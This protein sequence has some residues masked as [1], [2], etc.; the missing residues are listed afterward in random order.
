MA[1]TNQRYETLRD[2][3]KS[4][5][6]PLAFVDLDAFDA[7]TDHVAAL[8]KQAGK[9]LR[10]GVKSLRCLPLN[11]KA[12]HVTFHACLEIDMASASPWMCITSGELSP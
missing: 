1:F 4:Q 2:L 11:G 6:L 8:A 5:R 10:I 9:T 12:Q 7:N 3:F